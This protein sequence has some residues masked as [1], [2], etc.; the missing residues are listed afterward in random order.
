MKL[1][2]LKLHFGFRGL[3][4]GFN[5]YFKESE[6]SG[7]DVEPICLVGL[8]GSGKSNVLEVI[9]EIFYYLETYHLVNRPQLHTF[10]TSFGFEIEYSIPKSSYDLARVDWEELR[11]ATDTTQEYYRIKIVKK[12]G[13]YPEIKAF[14]QEGWILCKNKDNNRNVGV[15]PSRIIG[16]SSGMNELISNPFIKI[17]FHYL[18]IFQKLTGESKSSAI[19]VNRMFFMD[20]DSNKL[21][22]LANF[23]FDI[24]GFDKSQYEKGTDVKDFG[25]KDLTHLKKELEV[26]SISSFSMMFRF[27]DS[28]NKPI[29]LPAELNTALEKLMRC[30]TSYETSYWDEKKKERYK[31]VKLFFWVNRSTQRA[32]HRNF[33][34][35]YELFRVLYLFRLL[36]NNLI[37]KKTREQIKHARFGINISAKLPK[38]EDSKQVFTI[39]DIAF[40]KKGVKN[41]VYYRQLSDGEHQFLHIMGTVLLMDSPGT[42]FVLDEPETHFN[43]EWRSQF[44][45]QINNCFTT[46]KREQEFIL[47]S[48]SPFIVSDCKP[49]NVYSFRRDKKSR[50]VKYKK[51]KFNTFGASVDLLTKEIFLKDNTISKMGINKIEEIKS[52][53]LETLEDI[54]KA[55]QA[56]RVL[57]ESVEKVLLFRELI[58]KENELKKND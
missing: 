12:F 38:Y 50:K 1:H 55:K 43:P 58:L 13:E 25:A 48:H 28:N 29:E 16:Y 41:P 8:N 52:M 46:K 44:I 26:K 23:L 49:H 10:K 4:S 34:T 21:V 31:S 14:S 53:P 36:N 19:E 5:I 56:S 24:D 11:S 45:Y 32:F 35:G 42:L 30:A 3:P 20:Y 33:G 37:G 18:D 7:E 39:N 15:L 6:S 27:R 22:T 57:G 47:T 2:Y 9:S 54:E 51:P 17:D 40:Y